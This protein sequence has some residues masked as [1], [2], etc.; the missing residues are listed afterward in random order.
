MTCLMR[1]SSAVISSSLMSSGIWMSSLSCGQSFLFDHDEAA[2]EESAI[3]SEIVRGPF[4]GS[5]LERS[6]ISLMRERR[7][8]AAVDN[9]DNVFG[10]FRVKVAE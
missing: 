1:R 3:L 2:A 9:I 7:L 6:R 5:I 8:F 4:Y 10:L